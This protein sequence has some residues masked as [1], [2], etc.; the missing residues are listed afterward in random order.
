MAGK[1]TYNPLDHLDPDTKTYHFRSIEERE[2]EKEERELALKLLRRRDNILKAVYLFTERFLR[3]GMTESSIE[4]ILDELGHAAEV[5]RVYIFATHTRDD[6]TLV[7]S[8]RYEW[9]LPGIDPQIANPDL[10]EL[11]F[12]ET[13]FARWVETLGKGEIIYGHVDDFPEAEKTLLSAQKIVSLMVAPIMVGEDWW[14]F[15]GFDDCQAW[16]EWAPVEIE[17]LKTAANIIGAAIQRNQAEKAVLDSEKKYRM[18]VENANE[19]IVITQ[20]GMLKFVNPQAKEFTGLSEKNSETG[21][22]LDYIHPDDRQMVVKHH[23]RRLAGEEVPE[24]YSMR[25]IDKKGKIK[26]VL[27]STLPPANRHWMP[28]RKVRKNTGNFLKA[29]RMP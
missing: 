22:F 7:T 5:S 1:P 3:M 4:P 14:G 17:A 16:R 11:P 6:Q 18:V 25:M 8:Q 20:D 19:G 21:S 9:V 26:W 12:V 10:Q 27:C 29:N 24:I 2:L 15:I 23:R 28:W 13:G